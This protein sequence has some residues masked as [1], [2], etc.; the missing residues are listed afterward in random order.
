MSSITS[1]PKHIE[2]VSSDNVTLS[3]DL[4]SNLTYMSILSMGGLPR[5]QVLEQCSRQR[6]KTAVFF[7]YIYLLAKRMG[8]E[9]TQAFQLVAEK[10]RA[11]S[12]KSLFLR[13]A[14]S[15][16]SGESEREFIAQE[17]KI[18]AE[19]YSNEYERSV[20][21]LRKW[22][23]AYAAIL[24]SVTL[25]MVVSL[26]ST[27]MG[28]LGQNFIVMMAF[29][30]FFITSVGVY[31]IYKSAPVEQ[32]TYETEHGITR[33]R[34]TARFL[35]LLALL[36]IPFAALLGIV[37][38]TSS[39]ILLGTSVFFLI[40]G[41]AL[42][43]AGFYAWKDDVNVA[44]IDS[45]LPTFV[46]SV[47]N[48]A[49][50]TGVTL[51][52]AMNR[53]DRRSMGSLEPHI[54]NL[55]T[56]LTAR[57]PTKECWEKFREETGSE[58]ASRATTMLVDGAEMGGRADLVGQVC[59]DYTQN[60]TQLRAKRQLTSATFSFL[61]VPMHGTMVFILVFVLEIIR[62]FN[63]K[64][65]QASS[66]TLGENAG[67]L[68]VPSGL[69]LPPGVGLPTSGS[70]SGGV[71]IFGTQDM[72]LISQMIVVVIII[73]TVANALAPKFAAGGSNLKIASFLS[74]SCLVSGAIL[75]LLP[76][77]TGKLFTI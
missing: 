44:K 19:R 45:D 43:P 21:N 5:D 12:V 65:V 31:V 38:G 77:L 53:I 10:A 42:L 59:S 30:L 68:E 40:C 75:G 64:L 27:M 71:D 16:A 13:F 29:T 57:L 62:N 60:V 52:E 51:T 76:V 70:L 54:E 14:A 74:I 20:E 8:M 36:L 9:Y 11:S 35:T 47:G 22:T 15:I 58:L 26:V 1:S 18:E 67:V 24:V 63:T 72:T 66:E 28:S 3:F 33:V 50:S 25:I 61:T 73:L 69:Q 48:V 46:R 41:V 37:V 32:M 17:A 55:H 23:D 6:F 56:R 34:R 39:G 7:E 2:K 4:L 49:G